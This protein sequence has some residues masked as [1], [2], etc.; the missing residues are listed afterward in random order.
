MKKAAF[1]VLAFLMCTAVV[2]AD[3]GISVGNAEHM[4]GMIRVDITN[5]NSFDLDNAR[6]RAYLPELGIM[7]QSAAVDLDDDDTTSVTLTLLGEVP[8][9]EYLV[10]IS[11]KKAGRRRV[12]YRYVIFE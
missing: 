7:T 9:G 6:V 1:F 3:S 5:R 2:M 8:E 10:R 12:V 11:V 4:D